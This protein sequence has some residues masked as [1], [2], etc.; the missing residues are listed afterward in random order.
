MNNENDEE[1]LESTRPKHDIFQT[2]H[3]K[4]IRFKKP[5]PTIHDL[6]SDKSK[7]SSL[8]VKSKS[9]RYN[10]NLNL[11][12]TINIKLSSHNKKFSYGVTS[13]G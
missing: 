4:N 1:P 10:N 12:P 2:S 13:S 7:N 9:S 3:Q 8:K 6:K 5:K 11:S